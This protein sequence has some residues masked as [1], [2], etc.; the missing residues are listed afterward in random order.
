MATI[1]RQCTWRWSNWNFRVRWCWQPLVRFAIVECGPLA[2][3]WACDLDRD[4]AGHDA[5][6]PC[7]RRQYQEPHQ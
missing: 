6:K 2:M 1:T 3:T 7:A 5:E 4:Y